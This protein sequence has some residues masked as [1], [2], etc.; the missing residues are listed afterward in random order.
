MLNKPSLSHAFDNP[1]GCNAFLLTPC[2]QLWRYTNHMDSRPTCYT[3][4]ASM[5][6][7]GRAH[8]HL[9]AYRYGL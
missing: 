9:Y 1:S 2:K 6:A 4:C 7:A 5:V 3:R 8:A